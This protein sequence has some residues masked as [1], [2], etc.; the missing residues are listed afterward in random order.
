MTMQ[1]KQTLYVTMGPFVCCGLRHDTWMEVVDSAVTCKLVGASG[2]RAVNQSDTP[3]IHSIL[4]GDWLVRLNYAITTVLRLN[5]M[6]QHRQCFIQALRGGGIPANSRNSPS[7]KARW[8][9]RQSV[10]V[11]R[12]W[13]HF[14]RRHV[15][16]TTF[17]FSLIRSQWFDI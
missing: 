12:K 13:I 4:Y 1:R 9:L 6:Q 16:K 15:R 5:A 3:L 10:L 17:T 7:K 14:W 2:T 11:W 8:L